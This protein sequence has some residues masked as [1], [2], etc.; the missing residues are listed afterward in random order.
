MDE[1]RSSWTWGR[2]AEFHVGHHHTSQTVSS[3]P[4]FQIK[5][6]IFFLYS[7]KIFIETIHVK[8]KPFDF[9]MYQF[10]QGFLWTEYWVWIYILH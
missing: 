5:E 1:E 6:F 2:A 8:M 3:I 4:P 7:A 9:D 10:Q